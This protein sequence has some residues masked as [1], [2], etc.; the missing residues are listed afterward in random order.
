MTCREALEKLYDVIDNEASQHDVEKVKEHLRA[1]KSCLSRFEF[2]KLFKAFVSERAASSSGTDKLKADIL[3]RCDE[4]DQGSESGKARRFRYWPIIVIAAAALIICVIAS[5]PTAEFYR[6]MVFIS[7]F[8]ETHIQSFASDETGDTDITELLTA[9]DRLTN[10]MKLT[11]SGEPAGFSLIG[12]DL[13]EI[14]DV[15][16]TR[17]KYLNSGTP[18]SLFVGLG[19][20]VNLPDFEKMQMAQTEYFKHVC[21]DCQVIYWRLGNYIAIAVSEDLDLDMTPLISIMQAI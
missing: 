3:K 15:E 17:F 21:P 12:A 7:P 2:E 4:I 10:D 13:K 19:E 5:F 6:H 11:I 16:F 14:R 9:R 8:E 18:V 1:C 20:G